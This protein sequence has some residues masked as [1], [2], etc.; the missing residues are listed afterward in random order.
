MAIMK[1]VYR[2]DIDIADGIEFRPT[3]G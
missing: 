2:L 3:N 1:I